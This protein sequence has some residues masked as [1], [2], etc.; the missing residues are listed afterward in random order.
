[1]GAR[2]TPV[3]ILRGVEDGRSPSQRCVH[4]VL[5]LR[6]NPLCDFVAM[7]LRHDE[8]PKQQG[9]SRE[10]SERQAHKRFHRAP[11]PTFFS[12]ARMSAMGGMRPFFCWV[13][14]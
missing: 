13:G 12:L 1:M 8:K 9:T 6:R 3:L 5:M 4:E 14:K 7:R 10:Q 11:R 2:F